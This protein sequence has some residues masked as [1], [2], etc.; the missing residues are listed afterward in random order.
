VTTTAAQVKSLAPTVHCALYVLGGAY[1][2][3]GDLGQPVASRPSSRNTACHAGSR[4]QPR[5]P[6]L[7]FRQ[8]RQPPLYIRSAI[9]CGTPSTTF[10]PS[11]AVRSQHYLRSGHRDYEPRIPNSSVVTPCPPCPLVSENVRRMSAACLFCVCQPRAPSKRGRLE[12]VCAFAPGLA[13]AF[14]PRGRHTTVSSRALGP[15]VLRLSHL[16]L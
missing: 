3:S 11:S 12:G 7:D 16:P 4:L 1:S 2:M 6:E 13:A 10:H 8:K 14:T 15:S 5:R 9:A